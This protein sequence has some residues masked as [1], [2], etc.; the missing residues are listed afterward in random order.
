MRPKKSTYS[1][2]SI[3]KIGNKTYN[4]SGYIFAPYITTIN[5]ENEKIFAEFLRQEREKK[6]KR[7][8]KKIK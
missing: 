3:Q 2:Y 7:I 4:N 1:R 5:I 6:L 8:L